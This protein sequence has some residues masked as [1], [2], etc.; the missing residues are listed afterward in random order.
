MKTHPSRVRESLAMLDEL[1]DES[2]DGA[3]E[4]FPLLSN[5]G[6]TLIFPRLK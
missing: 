5:W 1:I 3:L 2:D 6:Q 4:Q